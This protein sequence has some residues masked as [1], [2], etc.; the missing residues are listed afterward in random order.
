MSGT[1]G[2]GSGG[3]GG[4]QLARMADVKISNRIFAFMRKH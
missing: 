3:G 1:G 2:G 4:A